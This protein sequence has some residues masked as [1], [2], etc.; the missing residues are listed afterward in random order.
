MGEGRAFFSFDEAILAYDNRTV[1][2]QA[3]IQVRLTEDL[4]EEVAP[5]QAASSTRRASA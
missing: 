2:L 4:I 3:K 5:R 1:D